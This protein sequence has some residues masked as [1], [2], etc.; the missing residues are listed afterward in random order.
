[1]KR[2]TEMVADLSGKRLTEDVARLKPL[3]SNIAEDPLFTYLKERIAFCE[4]KIEEQ[5]ERKTFKVPHGDRIFTRHPGTDLT[6]RITVTRL[7]K[8]FVGPVPL[9]TQ[10]HTLDPSTKLSV[11]VTEESSNQ[12]PAEENLPV[13]E[14]PPTLEDDDDEN[15]ENSGEATFIEN[16]WSR[17]LHLN[18]KFERCPCVSCYNK[19]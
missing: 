4:R 9:G 16:L 10:I 12:P 6:H 14:D 7:P 19:K 15:D 18:N 2:M 11:T 1:M 8:D 3:Y 13:E 17:D 5:S